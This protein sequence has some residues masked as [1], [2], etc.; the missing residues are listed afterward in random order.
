M[1][2]RDLLRI[3]S[4]TAVGAAAGVGGLGGA[5]SRAL[6]ASATPRWPGHRPGRIYLGVSTGDIAGTVRQTG[7]VGLRRRYFDWNDLDGE[8]RAIAAERAAGRMPWTSFQ[9]PLR[10]TGGWAAV[11]SGRYDSDIRARA[12]RYAQLNGPAIVTFSHEPHTDNYGSA[13]DFAAAWCRVH[14]VMWRETGLRNVASVPI[15]GDWCF[16]PVNRDGNPGAY[17]TGGV[18][19]R[20]AFLGVD[21]YQNASSDGY[22]E[23]LGRILGWL[24]DRG[25][26][27]KMVGVGETGCTDDYRSPTGAQWWT[28]SWNW[29]V[30]NA[31]RVG[32]ISYFN[33]RRHNNNGNNWLL[34]ESTS[35]LAAFRT[36]L[37]STVSCTL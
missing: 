8:M 31:D 18:L 22:P 19:D 9:P 23:R 1:K 2:R 3:A 5:G 33:S 11:A 14:D 35:K 20:C 7:A 21:L 25:H 27:G 17:I 24:D 16:N 32:A 15:I 6:A 12:R 37:G 30:A 4:L 34:S 26:S 29:A 13:A 10:T 28:R 36:S